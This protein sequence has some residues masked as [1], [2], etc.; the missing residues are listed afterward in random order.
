MSCPT[1]LLEDATHLRL[2]AAASVSLGI[3]EEVAA[4]VEGGLHA[5]GSQ[6]VAE[7]I[8]EGD[9]ASEGEQR[10]LQAAAA[11]SAVLHLGS[12]GGQRTRDVSQ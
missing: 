9:P 1:Q 2:A 7:L 4:A 10:N 8:V 12:H 5:L 6:V 11:E 3:V